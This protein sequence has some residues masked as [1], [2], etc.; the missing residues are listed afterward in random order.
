MFFW[1]S[2]GD[3]QQLQLFQTKQRRSDC[4]RDSL[5]LGNL[6][7]VEPF[8]LLMSIAGLFIIYTSKR[9]VK[10]SILPQ[11]PNVLKENLHFGTSSLKE[12]QWNGAV[13]MLKDFF[14]VW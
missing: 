8:H 1:G 2:T 9:S 7:Q 14:K 5:G 3:S 6:L 4:P 11:N 10:K 13:S 12:L